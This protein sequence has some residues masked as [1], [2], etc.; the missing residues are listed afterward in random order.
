MGFQCFY[1]VCGRESK[2]LFEV[3]GGSLVY[4]ELDSTEVVSKME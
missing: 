4:T 1:K 3:R 2:E